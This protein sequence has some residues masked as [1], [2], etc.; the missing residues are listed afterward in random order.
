MSIFYL[1]YWIQSNDE[2]KDKTLTQRIE[3][4]EQRCKQDN[5]ELYKGTKNPINCQELR[6]T[7]TFEEV[8]SEVFNILRDGGKFV[9]VSRD[10]EKWF[11]HPAKYK[12]Q[13]AK[14]AQNDTE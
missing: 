6:T 9:L 5:P 8:K 10:R 13:M 14:L 4:Y 11:C 3:E 7:K 12:K 1:A 2:Q